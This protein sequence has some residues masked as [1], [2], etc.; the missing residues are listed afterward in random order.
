V[1]GKMG[2]MQ[3]KYGTAAIVAVAPPGLAVAL[4]VIGVRLVLDFADLERISLSPLVVTLITARR[5][6]HELHP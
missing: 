3:E 4:L 5:V 1:G 2:S 6:R